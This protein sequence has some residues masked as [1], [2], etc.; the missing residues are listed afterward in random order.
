MLNTTAIMQ[1]TDRTYGGFKSQYR[2]NLE[3]F[4]DK[5]VLLEK[6]VSGPQHKHGLLVFGGVDEDTK[7]ELESAFDIRFLREQC[8]DLWKNWCCPTR[9]QMSW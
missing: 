4:V 5:L 7:L 3:L 6:S 8:L 2:C 9:P 1:E